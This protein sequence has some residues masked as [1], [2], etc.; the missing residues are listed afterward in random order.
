MKEKQEQELLIF[1]S[2]HTCFGRSKKS[3]VTDIYNVYARY[4]LIENLTPVEISFFLKYILN[5]IEK[6]PFSKEIKF[7]KKSENPCF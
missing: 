6:F 7:V 5:Y 2:E 1:F 4:C 3:L